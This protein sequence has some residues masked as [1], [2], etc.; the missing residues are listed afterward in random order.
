M[1]RLCCWRYIP[2]LHCSGSP[3]KNKSSILIVASLIIKLVNHRRK[4][5]YNKENENKEYKKV[6]FMILCV[7]WL[8][9]W[10]CYLVTRGIYIP[11]SHEITSW[12]V[13]LHTYLV[14]IIMKNTS[15]LLHMNLVILFVK[16]RRLNG[17][18]V[19]LTISGIC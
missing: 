15:S 18:G 17:V 19:V 7:I 2:K 3:S 4:I 12:N 14:G 10:S 11:R 9:L 5:R 6:Y 8:V 16:Y 1:F 13:K